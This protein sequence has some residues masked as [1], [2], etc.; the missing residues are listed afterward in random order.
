MQIFPADG[1]S[2][3]K[4]TLAEKHMKRLLQKIGLQRK[5]IM[6]SRFS[7]RLQEYRI[8]YPVLHFSTVWPQFAYYTLHYVDVRFL[9]YTSWE[10]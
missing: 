5:K 3:R 9:D 4:T 1:I 6:P 10:N 2:G 7:P 8:M